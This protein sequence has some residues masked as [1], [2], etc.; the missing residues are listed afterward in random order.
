MCI[1]LSD[2]DVP[3]E[4]ELWDVLYSREYQQACAA[5]FPYSLEFTIDLFDELAHVT[6]DRCPR[7]MEAKHEYEQQ[8]RRDAGSP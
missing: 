1:T 2:H 5:Q 7:C 4:R 8:S 6:A 3:I